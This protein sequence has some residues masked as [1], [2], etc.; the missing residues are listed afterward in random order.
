MIVAIAMAAI[1]CAGVAFAQQPAQPTA[2]ASSPVVGPVA[3]PAPP[4]SS[5][6][7]AEGTELKLQF[8]DALSSGSAVVGD[9][10]TISLAEPLT[11]APGVVLPAGLRGVGEVTAAEKKGMMGKGGALSVRVDYLKVGETR[12]R[13]RGAQG[14]AGSNA[15]GATITLV[16]LFGPLGLL[17][18]GHDMEIPKGQALKAYVDEDVNL[19]L[20]IAAAVPAG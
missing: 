3:T 17:K 10:F 19:P 16:V 12:I 9:R 5:V 20:P 6:R 1:A 7:L 2:V 18:H 14:G 15:E 4:P 11:I 13:L 8:E